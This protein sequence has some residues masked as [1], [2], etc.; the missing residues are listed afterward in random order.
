MRTA[1]QMP[2]RHPDRMDH[3]DDGQ[4]K[5]GPIQRLAATGAA[6][7]RTGPVASESE[8]QPAKRNAVLR[9]GENAGSAEM[10]RCQRGQRVRIGVEEDGAQINRQP[11]LGP[12]LSR[13]GGCRQRLLFLLPA[14][15]ARATA[16]TRWD[17][18]GA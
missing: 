11:I 14:M 13:G 6:W 15:A 12:I 17:R 5:P 9:G 4:R 16:G 18:F 2:C 7:A 8:S 10:P 1:G 3:G